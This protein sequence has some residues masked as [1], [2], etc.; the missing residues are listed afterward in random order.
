MVFLLAKE[1]NLK[2]LHSKSAHLFGTVLFGLT[3]KVY[4]SET[5]LRFTNNKKKISS[6]LL[7]LLLQRNSALLFCSALAKQGLHTPCELVSRMHTVF[8]QLIFI[9]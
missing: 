2:N 6:A 7:K 3:S 9:C 8:G 1:H 4:C 5:K